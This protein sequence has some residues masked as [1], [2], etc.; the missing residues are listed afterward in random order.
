LPR[1]NNTR[2]GAETCYN[3][4]HPKIVRVKLPVEVEW[5]WLSDCTQLLGVRCPATEVIVFELYTNSQ[6]KLL[7]PTLI[8]GNTWTSHIDK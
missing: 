1:S 2:E 4:L 7:F 8:V 6:P 5:S 3:L